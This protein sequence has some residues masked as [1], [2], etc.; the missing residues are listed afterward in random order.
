MTTIKEERERI[1]KLF[2]TSEF[3]QSA[4]DEYG[5]REYYTRLLSG[6]KKEIFFEEEGEGNE[7]DSQ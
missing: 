6:I 4:L 5:C 1:W 2:E 3:V 7:K